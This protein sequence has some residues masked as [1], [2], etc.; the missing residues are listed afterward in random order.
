MGWRTGLASTLLR[1]GQALIQEGD[2]LQSK[3]L[4]EESLEI[5][6]EL[7]ITDRRVYC[8]NIFAAVAGINRQDERAARLFGAAQAAAE[9][10]DVETEY[11]YHMTYD[12]IIADIR[13]Q[14]GEAGFNQAWAEG[15]KM[16]LEQA[17]E[18]AL[19]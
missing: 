12:P 2:A 8:L 11:F 19:N 6:R 16:T 13:E 10:L 18:L 9:E 15:R 17:V 1:L 7:N 5:Y 3:K 14:I 4:A